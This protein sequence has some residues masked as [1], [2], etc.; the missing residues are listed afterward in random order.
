MQNS[1]LEKTVSNDRFKVI[2]QNSPASKRVKFNIYHENITNHEN[3]PKFM[4]TSQPDDA[5]IADGDRREPSVH[6]APGAGLFSGQVAMF[7]GLTNLQHFT[8]NIYN[9]NDSKNPKS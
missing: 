9:N 3:R 1:R 4:L 2:K 8:F 6:H 7:Q 5:H